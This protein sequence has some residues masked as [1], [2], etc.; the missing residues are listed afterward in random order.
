MDASRA[1]LGDSPDAWTA[2][3]GAH[4]SID[5]MLMLADNDRDQLLATARKVF[6]TIEGQGGRVVGV[7]HGGVLRNK[8]NEGTEHFGFVDGR[9]Q[10]KYVASDVPKGNGSPASIDQWNPFEPLRRVLVRD[11]GIDDAR[12][13]GSF[14]VLR[15]L[16]QNVK[17]FREQLLGIADT[18][19]LPGD[20]EARLDHAGALVVGRFRDG[21]PIVQQDHPG[22]DPAQSNNFTYDKD[23]RGGRCPLHAHIRKVNPRGHSVRTGEA[24]EVERRHGITRRSMTYGERRADE[25]PDTLPEA[26]VGVLFTCYQASIEDQFAFMQQHWCNTAWFPQ[27][28]VGVDAL[29]GQDDERELLSAGAGGSNDSH[30]HLWPEAYARDPAKK[31]PFAACV[32]MQGGEFFFVPSLPFLRGL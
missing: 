28:Y 5:A 15:K 16:E 8:K 18:L 23:V 7:E 3:Y 25:T 29:V 13:H 21:T 32:T 2:P 26:G 31:A 1:A 12:C 10:P 4:G 19:G 17:R 14:L 9:S 20:T 30:Q 11:P 6:D 27:A 22:G 24:P